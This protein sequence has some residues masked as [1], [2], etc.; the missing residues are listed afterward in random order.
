MTGASLYSARVQR[1][2]NHE[3]LALAAGC[4]NAFIVEVFADIGVHALFHSVDAVGDS[5]LPKGVFYL[6]G[7]SLERD[8]DAFPDCKREKLEIPEHHGEKVE[9]LLVIVLAD[10]RPVE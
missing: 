8:G 7:V 4:F 6:R 1:A 10:I 2:G 3:L 5:G 9:I